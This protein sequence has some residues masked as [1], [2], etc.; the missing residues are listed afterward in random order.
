MKQ[1]RFKPKV[2]SAVGP[3]I[4]LSLMIAASSW[5][6]SS[7][8]GETAPPPKSSAEKKVEKKEKNSLSFWDGRLVLDLEERVRGEIRENNRDFDSSI[9]D[10]NDDSWLLN[11]FRFGLTLKP[12]SW[13]K[14]YAQTQD[15]REAFSDRANIP[16]V[17]GAEGDDIFDLRQAY[18]SIGDARKF[19][20][21][22][23]IGR[24]AITY[25]DGRLVG[26][27][28]FGNFGR[29]FDAI[30]LRF[31]EPHFGSSPSSPVRFKSS[32]MTSTITTPRTISAAPTSRPISCRNRRRTFTC[33]TAT[34]TITNLI[35]T[36]PI[37][38]I[39]KAPGTV[40]LLASRPSARG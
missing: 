18:I 17:R 9:N 40:P 10:D 28:K 27:S 29:T 6:T 1:T 2:K 30:R 35:S 23:T 15:S 36:Q 12:V 13:F 14:L 32:A 39:R 16:G 20:L 33:I 25:G 4:M 8:A 21:L 26:D 38:L 34:R 22:L 5:P 3:H 11:R 24:Q 7:P 31:E 19:P 37:K